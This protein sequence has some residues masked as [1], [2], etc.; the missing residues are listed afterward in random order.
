MVCMGD[1]HLKNTGG[2]C[3]HLSLQLEGLVVKE[4]FYLFKLGRVDFI[5]DVSWLARRS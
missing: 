3:K 5:L 4:K 2:C 1:G